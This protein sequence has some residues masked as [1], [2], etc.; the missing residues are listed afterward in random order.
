MKLRTM[1]RRMSAVADVSGW[2]PRTEVGRMVREGK[3]TDID[4]LFE[5]G[6]P[7]LEPEIVDILLPNLEYEILELKTTQR[8]TDNGRKSKFRVIVLV[9]DGNGHVGV[10][11]G[12]SDEVRPAIENALRNAKKNII[13][14]E[15]GC[16][17]WECACG[18]K[19]SLPFKTTGKYGSVEVVLKPAPK[20]LGLACNRINRKILGMAGVKD[21]WSFTRGHTC[22]VYNTAMATITALKKLRRIKGGM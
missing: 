16:G 17:S 19:H 13:K 15:T 1:G 21:V 11:V 14:V 2:M 9:G 7:I 18:G 4:Q 3:I 20:G 8:V 5:M 22:N 12:K 10:G 6:K